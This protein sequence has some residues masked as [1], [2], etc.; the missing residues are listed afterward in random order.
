MPRWEAVSS[1]L[2]IAFYLLLWVG[3]LPIRAWIANLNAWLGGSSLPYGFAPIWYAVSP[4]LV[5]LMVAS[6]VRDIVAMVRPDWVMLRAYVGIALHAGALLALIQLV[7]ADALFVVTDP[8][9]PGA[10][11]IGHFNTLFFMNLVIATVG[12]CISAALVVRR[13]VRVQEQRLAHT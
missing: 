11:H 12:V 2:L 6:M 5:V 7:R 9:G 10:A 3:V 4:I 1:F 8:A 13:V